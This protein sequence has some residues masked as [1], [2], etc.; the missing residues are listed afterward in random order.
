MRKLYIIFVFYSLFISNLFSQSQVI[1]KKFDWKIYKTEHFDVYYYKDSERLVPYASEV[2]E[3][4]YDKAKRDIAPELDRRIPFFLF[5]SQN[6]MEQNSIVDVGDG[7]GGLTEP[8]KNR[9]MVYGDG[10]KKWLREVIFHEFGHEAEFSILIDGWW[11]SPQIVKTVIYPLWMMEGIS[12]NMTG[13]WDIAMEDMFL[14][15]AV[16]DNNLIPLL[17]LFGFGHL[18]P[19][20]MTL[21]YKTG[22]KAMRFLSDEYGS[23]KPALMLYH[24]RDSYDIDTVLKKLINIDL[25]EFNKKF[26]YYLEIKYY[27][28]INNK[29]LVDADYY[30]VKITSTTDDIPAYNTSPVVITSNTIAY[31]ST[32]WGYPPSLVIENTENGKKKYISYRDMGVENIFYSRF[33]FA[34]RALSVSNNKRFLVFSAQKN[35]REYLCIYDLIENKFKKILVDGVLEARQFSFSADDKKLVFVGMVDGINQIYELDFEESLSK[36]TISISDLNKITDDENDKLS[37]QYI[38]DNSIAYSC[39]R[40]SIK[41]LKRNLCIVDNNRNIIEFSAGMDINDFSYDRTYKRF[42]FISDNDGIYS[43]YSFSTDDGIVYRHTRDIGGIF[44]PYASGDD[45]YFS[46]FRHQS[47]NIYRSDKRY[48]NYEKM[49]SL[50][51]VSEEKSNKP[52]SNDITLHSTPYHFK[53][54]T[55]LFFPALFFSSLDGLYLYTYWQASDY[56]GHNNL[57]VSLNYNSSYP[58]SDII[59]TYIYN[60]YRIKFIWSGRFYDVNDMDDK[61]VDYDRHYSR[62]TSGFIY[63]FDRYRSLGVYYDY[64]NDK[65]IYIDGRGYYDKKRGVIASYNSDTLN[66]L[67]LTAV[68]GYRY[69]LT[70]S[71]YSSIFDG[72]ILYKSISS[73]YVK[74][75]PVSRR[76]A[77]VNRFFVGFSSGRDTPEFS[78]GGVGGVRGF[79]DNS[80]NEE[81]N[82]MVYNMEYRFPLFDTDYYMRYFF[83]DFYFKSVYIKF[84]S[85]NAYPWDSSFN[86]S[87]NRIKNSLGFGFDVHSFVLQSYKVLLSL[88]LSFNMKSGTKILYFYL[89]PVF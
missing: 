44:T 77:I 64:K 14:R 66:G 84:F 22:S 23:D 81:R 13:E 18:K 47:I 32:L 60:K 73:D 50:K 19:H 8:Y 61:S 65:K 30:G 3:A 2:L 69:N 63:P 35:H 15:D 72:N 16:L 67:Y 82:V 20:Q 62:H 6:D 58:Y 1:I 33:S 49:G 12:E 88:D 34:L 25:N 37:P 29:E 5:A 43:L 17:K 74:Y 78:Y 21:A 46:S 68:Y 41:D 48:I 71:Y 38:D 85:D 89:G 75:F 9:F 55:D 36:K 11:K 51:A 83:P 57:S 4:A 52:E 26:N 45:L 56:T 86:P 7:T 70:A 79:I 31:L 87:L 42:Y 80:S 27:S 10:S 24:Y 28:D 59:S 53:A 40:G 54:S 76:S 39:E